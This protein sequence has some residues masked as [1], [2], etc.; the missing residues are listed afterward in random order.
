MKLFC[1][2][3]VDAK[4]EMGGVSVFMALIVVEQP[5]RPIPSV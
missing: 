3:S 2:R 4:L 5:V 1:Q